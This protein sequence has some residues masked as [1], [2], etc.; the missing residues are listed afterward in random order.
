MFT[1][2]AADIVSEIYHRVCFP[3]YGL[4]YVER[5]KYIR[6]DRHRLKYLAW[7]E[8]IGCVYC[9]YVN[10]WSHYFSAIAA[11]TEQ[12]WCAIRHEKKAGM[13]EQ[14]HQKDFIEYGDKEG[15]EKRFSA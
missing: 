9:A 14:P 6:I 5:K 3:L 12:Y 10:G 13:Y 2:L 4:P 15:F 7:Y 8:K 11:N 1:V